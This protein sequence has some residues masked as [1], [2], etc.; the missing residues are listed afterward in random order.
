MRTCGAGS[1]CLLGFTELPQIERTLC[2]NVVF[3]Y[4]FEHA[5]EITMLVH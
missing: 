5:G 1:L 2:S 3:S 4:H